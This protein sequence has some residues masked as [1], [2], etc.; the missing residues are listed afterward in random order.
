MT[1]TAQQ[2]EP[3]APGRGPRALV[4]GALVL[5]LVPGVIGFD[6]WPLTAWRLFSLARDDDQTR[7]V[8]EA[9]ISDGAARVVS[10]EELPL[11]YRNA[12]WQMAELPDAGADQRHGG[13]DAPAAAVVPVEHHPPPTPAVPRRTAPVG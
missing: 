7:W 2:H 13:G 12:E 9:E 3:R 1:D 5:L 4:V 6:A 11:R 8:L 10:L